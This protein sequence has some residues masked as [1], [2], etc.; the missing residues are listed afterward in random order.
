MTRA[1][2]PVRST[3][4][5]TSAAVLEKPPPGVRVL[6]VRGGPQETR[7]LLL[8]HLPQPLSDPTTRLAAALRTAAV[9]AGDAREVGYV[10]EA[11]ESRDA[12]DD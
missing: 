10:R 8:A 7:R 6:P 1:R 12:G 11:R 2:R 4:C 9:E 3:P 5:A